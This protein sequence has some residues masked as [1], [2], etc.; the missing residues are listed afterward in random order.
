ML[1]VEARRLRCPGAGTRRTPTPP[2]PDAPCNDA[3]RA[4]LGRPGGGTAKEACA[5]GEVTVEEDE[6]AVAPVV[7]AD[8]DD[9]G[10]RVAVGGMLRIKL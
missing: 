7:A 3:L 10:V 5:L 9:D 4:R 1:I 8:D 2:R 6:A